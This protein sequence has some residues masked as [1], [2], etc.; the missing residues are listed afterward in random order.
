MSE[1]WTVEKIL[2]LYNPKNR[3]SLIIYVY[4]EDER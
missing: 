1:E 2:D 3:P 4:E